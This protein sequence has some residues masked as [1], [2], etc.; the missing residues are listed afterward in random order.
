MG[1]A[2]QKT[3]TTFLKTLVDR[4]GA[5]E[6]AKQLGL[7]ATTIRNAMSDGLADPA[8][9][10]AARSLLDRMPTPPTVMPDVPAIPEA[11]PVRILVV[12]TS[13][14]AVFKALELM[15]ALYDLEV[16][17]LFKPKGE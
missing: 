6:T 17:E 3:P 15:R 10:I 2:K 11:A 14:P 1:Y 16:E 7:S 12:K 4:L 8:W 9:E 13:D 5:V